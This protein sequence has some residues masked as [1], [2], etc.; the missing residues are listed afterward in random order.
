MDAMTPDAF[1]SLDLLHSVGYSWAFYACAGS[2]GWIW[3]TL[4]ENGG[5]AWLRTWFRTRSCL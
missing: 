1:Y 5:T 3:S 4:A 2:V